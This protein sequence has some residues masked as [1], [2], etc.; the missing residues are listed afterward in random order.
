MN[1]QIWHIIIFMTKTH[2]SWQ[3]HSLCVRLLLVL[4]LENQKIWAL[5]LNSSAG[6]A[7]TSLINLSTRHLINR[8]YKPDMCCFN[9]R[10]V[11]IISPSI[12]VIHYNFHLHFWSVFLLYQTLSSAVWWWILHHYHQTI[13]FLT[14]WKE[15][16]NSVFSWLINI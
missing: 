13:Y 4:L 7:D 8:R 6:T 9:V 1:T 2:K 11:M 10:W 14:S 3:N 16:H 15:A 5:R 12:T